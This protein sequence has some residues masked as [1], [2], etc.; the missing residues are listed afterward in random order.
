MRHAGSR[1][2]G[3]DDTA[4][5]ETHSEV[6]LTGREKEREV[7]IRQEEEWME[8]RREGWKEGGRLKYSR[9]EEEE[10]KS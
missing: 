1:D 9:R 8:G 5:E 6:R 7:K 4:T 3:R 2:G 10:R